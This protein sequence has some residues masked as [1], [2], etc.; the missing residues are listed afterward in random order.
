MKGLSALLGFFCLGLVALVTPGRAA[1]T[2]G[3][4]LATVSVDKVAEVNTR[5]QD[6]LFDLAVTANQ[7]DRTLIAE[8][9]SWSYNAT[10]SLA[11]GW[12]TSADTSLWTSGRAPLGFVKNGSV[13][14]APNG[15]TLLGT[16]RN[17]YYFH[18][19][20]S[21]QEPNQL[22]RVQLH[23][24]F[25]D[26]ARVYVNG[27]S[28]LD[29]VSDGNTP[30]EYSAD[31]AIAYRVIEISPVLL[32]AGN[33][34]IA[35]EV[36]STGAT[37]SDL[38]FD[39]E[40]VAVPQVKEEVLIDKKSAGWQ[41]A[42]WP[43][44]ST[45]EGDRT[46]TRRVPLTITNFA[47]DVQTRVVVNYDSDM[48]R[49]FGDVRFYDVTAGTFL[50]YWREEKSDGV[51]ATFWIKSG[52]NND[53]SLNYG[54]S[55][56]TYAGDAASVFLG[57]QIFAMVGSIAANT[58]FLDHATA[59]AVRG[60]PAN[61]GSKY[62]DNIY[63]NSVWDGT[64][65]GGTGT[66]ARDYF[67]S[68][69]RFLFVPNVSGDW[70]FA[71]D[72][73]DGSEL[74]LNPADGNTPSASMVKASWYGPH[75]ACGDCTTYSGT[76]NFA[77]AGQGAWFDYTHV[78]YN[79]GEKASVR[80]RTPSGSWMVLSASNLPGQIFARTYAAS[81]PTVTLGA[82]EVMAADWT[83]SA[84]S[85]NWIPGR[86]PFGFGR[87]GIATTVPNQKANYFRKTVN[88][89]TAE[90]FDSLSLRLQRD[91]G[92]VVYLNGK[93]LLRS[94]MPG[95]PVSFD[96]AP[97]QTVDRIEGERY[98]AVTVP[99]ATGDLHTGDNVF[100]VEVHQHPSE[101]T[102]VSTRGEMT[103]TGVGFPLRLL[104]H[105]DSSGQVRLLKEA[106]LMQDGAGKQV[107]LADAAF[108]ANYRGVALRG[109]TMVGL[110]TSAIGY[111]FAGPAID[112]SGSLG[113]SGSAACSLSLSADAPTNPFLHRY[114]PDHDNLGTDFQPLPA[115]SAEAYAIGR[116]LALNFSNR[117][118]ANPAEVERPASSRPPG[119]GVT[120]LGG[121]YNETLTGLHKETLGVSGWFTMERIASA[122]I[123]V[124]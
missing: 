46:L 67:Y 107:I 4:W 79:G 92:A 44:V 33:N 71:I 19:T 59:N 30:I 119:W 15:G 116:N 110:R 52:A 90:R 45:A 98:Q 124:K 49:D 17:I 96:T 115:G 10:E 65:P 102:S 16:G 80:V 122:P 50:P 35:V 56:L 7:A 104:L 32:V 97:L 22:A 62:V 123:L 105:V 34:T 51:S 121:M 20:F 113:A 99:L 95:G 76:H 28:I 48:R 112:C 42:G 40:L 9:A 81:E 38:Y 61:I 108:A 118:P 63:W 37:D 78:E 21:V 66:F 60:L 57:G 106:I 36:H 83:P 39:L 5:I 103:S 72:S 55:Q 12:E 1:D 117:Y 24:W 31:P 100:I 101:L 68:R 114:H 41:H 75:A 3:L 25:D 23:G 47:A 109:E 94:N 86:A 29:E 93:E 91:D 26:A 54:N 14:T 84:S 69:F 77:V 2:S 87:E 43:S 82:E 89:A 74:S 88:V 13:A 58:S 27:S 6:S 11:T 18:K 85:S 70:Q 53:I 73:D 111:D 8:G 120:I 64:S